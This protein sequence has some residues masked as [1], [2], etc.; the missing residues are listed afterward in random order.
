MCSY[1][2]LFTSTLI[3]NHHQPDLRNNKVSKINVLD[4][5]TDDALDLDTDVVDTLDMDQECYLRLSLSKQ[6]NWT[7]VSWV[8]HF[9]FL[10]S[11]F[12]IIAIYRFLDLVLI[13]RNICWLR[14]WNIFLVKTCHRH[15][16]HVFQLCNHQ[17]YN[18][19]DHILVVGILVSFWSTA[20][21]DIIWFLL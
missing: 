15:P 20:P 17:S 7:I 16:G 3:S 12:Y 1:C 4:A 13:L 14:K 19:T 21:G 10:D 8:I 9:Y 5:I 2:F 6:L 18:I 11:N